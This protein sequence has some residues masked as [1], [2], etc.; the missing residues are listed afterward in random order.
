MSKKEWM[1]KNGAIVLIV[2][3]AILG[4]AAVVIALLMPN[5]QGVRDD[6]QKYLSAGKHE[7]T[8][9]QECVVV[10]TSGEITLNLNN[11]TITCADGPAI[12]IEEAKS[13]TI[14]LTGENEINS[15]TTEELDGAIYSTADMILSGNG[16]LKVAANYD[17][18]VSKDA[19]VIICG[20]YEIESGDDGIRGK[21]YVVVRDGAFTIKA[22]GDGIKSSNDE[23]AKLGYIEID[24]GTFEIDADVDGIQAE[25]DITIDGG[26][27]TINCGDDAIHADGKLAIKDGTIAVDA[28]EGLEATYIKIDGGKI[29]I[30]ADD[31][32]MNAG[33]KSNNYK[34]AIEINGGEITIK[35]GAGD[36]DAIDSNGDISIS[37]GVIDI[38]ATSPFDYDGTAKYTGGTI[39]VNGE[40]TN[41]I[42]NQVIGPPAEA[43]GN[44][45]RFNR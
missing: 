29:S 6:S 11:A 28:T 21:D 1:K 25:T 41:K 17:G 20:K 42:T 34:V 36:T 19:L 14:N 7:L 33:N 5:I 37:G 26:E 27:I 23:D 16:N 32:G 35:V 43:G 38:T 15:T 9:E 40:T 10:K 4:V 12:Y 2:V 44:K 24:S 30:N 22:G 31:D 39:I 13:V 8:G 3:L 18:I 45:W